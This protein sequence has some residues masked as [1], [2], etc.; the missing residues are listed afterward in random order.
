MQYCYNG[1]YY[2][3][4]EKVLGPEN[5]ALKFGDALFETILVANTNC[6]YLDQHLERLKRGMSVMGMEMPDEYNQKY[7]ERKIRRLLNKNHHIKG[8]RLRLTVFRNDGGLYTPT[9]NKISFILES[10]ELDTIGYTFNKTGLSVDIYPDM[11]KQY[12]I[13]SEFKSANASLFV[14][15][16]LWRQ[17]NELDDCIILNDK[18][19]VCEALSSNVFIIK[20][21]KIYTPPIKSGCVNGIMRNVVVDLLRKNNIEVDT[22]TSITIDDLNEAEELFLTNSISGIRKVL[23]FRD[24]R[25]YSMKTRRISQLLSENS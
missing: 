21:D 16:G 25:Y 19:E 1:E 18:N 11:G 7:F 9:D 4:G 17:K 15:A 6:Y 14:L 2:K 10:S 22:E 8:A 23:I 24:K 20:N 13:I 5:R 3:E 12:N